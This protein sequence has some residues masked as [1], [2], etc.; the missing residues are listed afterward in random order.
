MQAV[1]PLNTC[2]SN[3]YGTDIAVSLDD[4]YVGVVIG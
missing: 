2:D 4:K 3:Y 1:V